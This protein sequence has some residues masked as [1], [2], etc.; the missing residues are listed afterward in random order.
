MKFILRISIIKGTLI[1]F[2]NNIFH[3]LMGL[4][5]TESWNRIPVIF[6]KRIY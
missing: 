2:P 1:N 4:I 6:I 5:T 3:L